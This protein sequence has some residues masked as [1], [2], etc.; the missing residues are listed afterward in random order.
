ML[1]AFQIANFKAFADLQRIPI[2]PLTLIYGVNSAGKSSI[3]HSLILAR[4]AL[5]TGSLDV[6]RTQVG[7]D[8][9]DLGGFRQYVHRRE[10]NRR[11]EWSAEFAAGDFTGPI[12]E[13]LAPVSDITLSIHV[14]VLLDDE[15]RPLAEA[16]PETHAFTIE[17][18]GRSILRMS[19]R[20]D[21]KLQLDRLDH[22][23]P[24]FREALRAIVELSTT[25]ADLKTS[26]YDTLDQ[27]MSEI[28]PEI[29]AEADSFIPRGLR[30]TDSFAAGEQLMLFAVSKGCRQ[31][32]LAGRVF[33]GRLAGGV[34][35]ALLA[36]YALTPDVFD[37]TA[38]TSEDVG[39]LQ[40]QLLKEVL[41]SEGLVRD[42]RDGEWCCLLRGDSRPWHRRG[43][44]L[45]KE[46]VL[47]KR[48]VPFVAV[49]A[50]VPESD[51]EWCR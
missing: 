32:D 36:E 13:L 45:L 1:T 51:E 5:E 14:G 15:D 38:Y 31:E 27:V 39:D 20:K 17:A 10:A 30:R 50:G 40:L 42:L 49:V 8:A 35:M 21:G 37:L 3:L 43:K 29:T 6:H 26:D 44:E 7:G 23:L 34:L 46:L 11:L 22:H 33:R 9:V 12:A 4:H 25:A 18:D 41:L 28:V 2:R 19:R 16:A 48:L 47:Q 24:F